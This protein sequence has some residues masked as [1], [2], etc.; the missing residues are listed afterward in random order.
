M[1]A[2]HDA[3]RQPYRI[4][5]I[6][7]SDE[8][9]DA[10]PGAATPGVDDNAYTNVTAAW[11]LARRLESAAEPPRTRTR[12]LEQQLGLDAEA[13]NSWEDVSRHLYVLPRHGISSVSSRATEI[14]PSWTRMPTEG[15]TH[16]RHPPRS[17]GLRF[18][19]HRT[20][21][22]GAR[23][24]PG[25]TGHRP[26]SPWHSHPV[27][28]RQAGYHCS[29]VPNG[30]SPSAVPA[31]WTGRVRGP[32]SAAVVP[33]GS[34]LTSGSRSAAPV[35]EADR[36]RRSTRSASKRA[37]AEARVSGRPVPRPSRITVRSRGTVPSGG[38]SSDRPITS[39]QGR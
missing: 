4:R 10:Y 3:D 7:G 31:R 2:E 32:R 18:R 26:P 13:L 24:R 14:W 1:A 35:S 38:C 6:M 23:G 34:R 29:L 33:H 9:H 20:G 5:G 11:V 8:Y 16:G 17:H 36:C 12:Q 19:P 37:L 25:R 28:P 21:H 30:P 15:G 39:A 27:R 22:R